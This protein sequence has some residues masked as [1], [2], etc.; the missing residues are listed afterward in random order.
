MKI[1]GV[2]PSITR[3]GISLPDHTTFA[4]KPPRPIL[5][6]DRLEYFADHIGLA[7]RSA[8]VDLVVMEDA[9]TTLLGNAG[10]VLLHL[11]G[12]VRLE[13]KRNKTP[14]MILSPS[15][16]KKFATGSGAADKDAMAASALQLL[17]RTYGTN[18]EC[19][20]DWLR[21]AGRMAY[22][23][24]EVKDVP[25]PSLAVDRILTMPQDQLQALRW[26]GTGK[27]RHAIFWPEVGGRRPWPLIGLRGVVLYD[28][29]QPHAPG[30]AVLCQMCAGVGHMVCR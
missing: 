9:P 25:F 27:K 26:A 30:K 6:D 18:D 4:I 22:G 15:T 16:L 1:M 12:A 24:P 23:L 2:D 5:G 19:D 7:A 17:G 13:L 11:Q 20:A 21:I 28:E 8:G 29:G 3:T 10:R 14:Y